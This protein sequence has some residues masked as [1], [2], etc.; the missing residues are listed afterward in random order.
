MAASEGINCEIIDLC[1]L[2]PWDVET[3]VNSV[4]KTGRLLVSH[5]APLS[6]GFAGEIASTVSQH[7]FLSL[8]APV[9]RVCGY[10]TPF[11]LIFERFYMPDVYK[12][13]EAIKNTVNF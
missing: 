8:E 11:P 4:T 13:F 3:V 9:A 12:N 1:T 2:Q 7:A 10:D 6:G 5:E